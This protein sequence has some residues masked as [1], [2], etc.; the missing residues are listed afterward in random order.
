[1]KKCCV[2]FFN[3]TSERRIDQGF[4]YYLLLSLSFLYQ[5]PLSLK[6]YMNRRSRL[7]K[8]AWLGGKKAGIFSAQ[9]A[10]GWNIITRKFPIRH[11]FVDETNKTM[12]ARELT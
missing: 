7:G 9:E 2:G 10:E 4:I 1:M 8:I 3:K 11:Y 12:V 5:Q 6:P